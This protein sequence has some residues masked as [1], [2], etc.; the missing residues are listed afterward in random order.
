MDSNASQRGEVHWIAA[1]TTLGPVMIAASAQGVC[2]LAFGSILEDLRRR[3]PAAVL[4]QG[5]A[6]VAA[7]ADR[8][9][10]AI[11]APS[12]AMLDIPI[13]AAGTPFQQEVWQ[14]LR[15]IPLGATRSYGELAAALGNSDASRAVGGANRANRIA[16]LIPCHRVVQ[17]NGALGGYAWGLE[18]KAELLR[19]E[20]AMLLL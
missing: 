4:V 10:A 18:V 16:V 2:S 8:V 1:Q 19:R 6:Q 20:G 14:E 12:P 13:D 7:L 3:F 9:V 15:R 5:G 11:E 17:T